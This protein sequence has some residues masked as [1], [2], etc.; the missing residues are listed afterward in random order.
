[1]K[2]HTNISYKILPKL[3]YTH[4]TS[5]GNYLITLLFGRLDIPVD[6]ELEDDN[7]VEDEDGED[8]KEDERVVYLL[9]HGKETS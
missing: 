8:V 5:R 2:I 9:D 1:M 3:M 4:P 7:S 6:E